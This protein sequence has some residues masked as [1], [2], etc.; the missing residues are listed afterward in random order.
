M[1]YNQNFVNLFAD[2]TLFNQHE[3]ANAGVLF[4][5]F[6]Y[7]L[8][9]KD[10]SSRIIGC[11]ELE[12]IF[13]NCLKSFVA[14]LHNP[15]PSF[16]VGL[17]NPNADIL[18]V[19]NELAIN[20]MEPNPKELSDCTKYQYWKLLFVNEVLLNY[21][22]WKVKN[23][24]NGEM[25]HPNCC[26]QDP[27]FPSAFCRLCNREKPGG[28]YWQKIN[29][30]I[31]L[32][33]NKKFDFRANKKEDSFFNHVF[34]TELNAIPSK[35][36]HNNHEIEELFARFENLLTI[37]FYSEFPIKIFS[38]HNYLKAIKKTEKKKEKTEIPLWEEVLFEKEYKKLQVSSIPIGGKEKIVGVYKLDEKKIIVTK[39]FNAR[40]WETKD[41][42]NLV[43]LV[44]NS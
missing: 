28:H 20:P 37:P 9:R 25:V 43:K 35:S 6:E 4:N 36:S 11:K 40:G 8:F 29:G 15:C 44:K 17:G 1:S 22:V 27:E 30:L 5:D 12:P 21:Y 18:I 16:H 39:H 31:S 41:F 23:Q 24:H 10:P 2:P 42:N 38:C 14:D 32:L 7:H 26:I 19:G 33:E 34:L 3:L 13:S